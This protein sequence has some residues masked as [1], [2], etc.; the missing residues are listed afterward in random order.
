MTRTEQLPAK[1]RAYFEAN[2]DE[3]LTPE[4]IAVKFDANPVN[5][6]VALRYM[7]KHGQVT[8]QKVVLVKKGGA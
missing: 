7:R 2:P 8:V 5:V 6:E 3:E 4:D 1:L